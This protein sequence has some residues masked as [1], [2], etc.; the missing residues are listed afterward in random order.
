MGKPTDY[1]RDACTAIGYALSIMGKIINTGNALG[2]DQA[3]AAGANF[4]TPTKVQL[5]C[6]DE[7]HY[8]QAW[9]L[10]NIIHA[11]QIQEWRDIAREH[12]PKYDDLSVYVRKLMDRNVGII[13]SSDVVIA[14]PNR[15]KSWGGGT[16]HGMKVAK[17]YGKP[18]IDISD[19][20]TLENLLSYLRSRVQGWL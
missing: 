3:Y 11:N 16:G 7:R 14:L 20:E 9:C 13:L 19:E 6:P 1:H 4:F 8:P 12:H 5:F 2:C 18:V 17:T 10:G 15:N